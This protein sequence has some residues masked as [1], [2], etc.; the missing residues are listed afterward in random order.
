MPKR[1]AAGPSNPS[2]PKRHPPYNEMV[3]TAI[4]ELKQS[5]DS[6]CLAISKYLLENYSLPERYEVQVKKAL[7]RLVKKK[8]IVQIQHSFKIKGDAV[9]TAKNKD[10]EAIETSDVE[11]QGGH[12]KK[13]NATKKKNPDKS[14][15]EKVVQKME[16]FSCAQEDPATSNELAPIEVKSNKAVSVEVKRF[17]P[18]KGTAGHGGS[19]SASSGSTEESKA[20]GEGN[21]GFPSKKRKI[22]TLAGSEE[23][24]GSPKK[25]K[26]TKSAARR[27]KR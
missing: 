14:L 26:T 21:E 10:E 19:H 1:K 16:E 8:V 12:N 13:S 5:S 17:V 22:E 25:S 11:L 7:G 9:A 3:I 4:N 6:S 2:E 23:K 18:M 15:P 24:K 20:N 27:R